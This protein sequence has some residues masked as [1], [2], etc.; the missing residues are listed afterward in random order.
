M[1]G[2]DLNNP[3]NLVYPRGIIGNDSTVGFRM[4]GSYR[5]PYDVTLAG[6]LVSNGGYPYVS[7]YNVTRAIALAHGVRLTPTSV[8]VDLSERGEERLPTVTMADIRLSRAFR[9]GNR[10]IVPQLDIFNI[11]N[12]DTAVSLNNTLGSAYLDTREILSPR[13]IRVGFSLNF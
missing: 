8:S 4:S 5:M 9:F 3:N 13:I 11:T 6:S 10:Q 12:A 1:G 7:S 2:D